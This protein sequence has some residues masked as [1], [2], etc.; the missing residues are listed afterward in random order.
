MEEVSC[1][2][3]QHSSSELSSP[4]R[5]SSH[6]SS[7]LSGVI[8][9]FSRHATAAD[10][11]NAAWILVITQQCVRVYPASAAVTGSRATVAKYKANSELAAGAV[12]AAPG[13]QPVA[14]AWS[15]STGI[16]VRLRSMW[17]CR[18]VSGSVM[19]SANESMQHC[20]R[21]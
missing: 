6:P 19:L 17:E 9:T 12:I 5:P 10:H 21:W 18:L 11:S 15:E 13:Q 14:I 3:N 16:H 7:P 2:Q 8:S 1:R 20:E 4:R